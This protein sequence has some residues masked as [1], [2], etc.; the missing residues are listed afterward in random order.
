[1]SR[2][3]DPSATWLAQIMTLLAEPAFLI[4]LPPS[5]KGAVD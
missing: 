3:H 2:P 1:M 4:R 5:E